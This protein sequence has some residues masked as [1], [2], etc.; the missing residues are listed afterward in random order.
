MLEIILTAA[1]IDNI[2][3]NNLMYKR[4]F[5]HKSNFSTNR[6]FRSTI[7]V[8]MVKEDVENYV[9]YQ[10]KSENLVFQDIPFSN[11]LAKTRN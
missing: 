7:F 9:I 2:E 1:T 10:V 3:M 8:K 11:F 5:E 4:T 6:L